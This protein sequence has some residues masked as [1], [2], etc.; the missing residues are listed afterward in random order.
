MSFYHAS[1]GRLLTLII[2]CYR[3]DLVPYKTFV[4]LANTPFLYQKKHSFYSELLV[5]GGNTI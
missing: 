3:H 2:I 4:F 1:A 5:L